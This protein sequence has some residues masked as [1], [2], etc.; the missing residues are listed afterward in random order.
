MIDVLDMKLLDYETVVKKM[1][2]ENSKDLIDNDTGEHAKILVSTLVD[3][4]KNT[5]KIYTYSFCETFYLYE[6][7]I[8]AFREAAKRGVVLQIISQTNLTGNKALEVYKE[9][10]A[11][12][13][14]IKETPIDKLELNNIHLNNFMII[15]NQGIRY[16]QENNYDICE[17]LGNIKARGTFNRENEIKPIADVFDA[18]MSEN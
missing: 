18:V 15:D 11:G 14:N 17:N 16:E 9:I 12:K 13:L 7:V 3:N 8:N 1:A 2:K 6:K 4:S 10:F 5:I